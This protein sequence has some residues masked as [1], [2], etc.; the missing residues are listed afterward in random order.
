MSWKA[1]FRAPAQEQ[2]LP[3]LRRRVQERLRGEGAPAAVVDNA[4]LLISELTHNAVAATAGGR[5]VR[6]EAE[7]TARGV[8][9]Q[10]ECDAN[11]DL[12]GLVRALEAS[13]VLPSPESERGRGLWLILNLSEDLQVQRGE[14]GL[15]RVSLIVKGEQA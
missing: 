14:N 7:G 2:A 6:V 12:V 13:G 4:G 1:A 11:R 3:E 10:V 9:L 15:V 5:E 8:R